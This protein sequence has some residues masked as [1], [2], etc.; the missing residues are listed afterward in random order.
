MLLTRGWQTL[1][2][3]FILRSC[4]IKSIFA[5][6]E[7]FACHLPFLF[8]PV[9]FLTRG[10]P[11]VLSLLQFLS[12]CLQYVALNCSGQ[13]G[14]QRS[15]Q[16]HTRT[17]WWTVEDRCKCNMSDLQLYNIYIFQHQALD[18]V[19]NDDYKKY[20]RIGF[21]LLAVLLLLDVEPP[22]PTAPF[23]EGLLEFISADFWNTSMVALAMFSKSEYS[24]YCKADTNYSDLFAW[25]NLHNIDSRTKRDR[26]KKR[27]CI[28]CALL[29][30]QLQLQ[31]WL[32]H[33]PLVH[34]LFRS[35]IALA[36]NKLFAKR[37]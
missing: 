8:L 33:R 30:H 23:P 5:S 16:P 3:I 28:V 37:P 21:I 29:D 27:T 2:T 1:N 11:Q 20:L 9:S 32:S 26:L 24:S 10:G 31:W 35:Q 36:R 25:L 13:L 18:L 19:R 6:G 7:V 22:E 15:H 34:V 4:Q 14:Y 17:L 12:C